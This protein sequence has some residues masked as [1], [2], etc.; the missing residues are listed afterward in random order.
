MFNS[1]VQQL[2]HHAEH[3]DTSSFVCPNCFHKF[4]GKGHYD[5][6]QRR[7]SQHA[8]SWRQREHDQRRV[9]LQAQFRSLPWILTPREGA[10]GLPHGDV[11]G[12]KDATTESEL[13]LMSAFKSAARVRR[14]RS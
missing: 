2:A 12:F 11:I 6:G 13:I 5:V 10:V 8:Q 1:V 14:H 9:M 3:Q 4:R 7:A